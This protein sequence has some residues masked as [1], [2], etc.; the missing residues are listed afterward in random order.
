MAKEERKKNVKRNGVWSS[1]VDAFERVLTQVD[2]ILCGCV[3]I[4]V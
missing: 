4:T 3:E 2:V 1:Y